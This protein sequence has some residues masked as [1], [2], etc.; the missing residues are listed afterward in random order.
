MNEDAGMSLGELATLGMR[1][2]KEAQHHHISEPKGELT[3]DIDRPSEVF[4]RMADNELNVRQERRMRLG[5]TLFGEP[6]WEIL[7]DAYLALGE[8]RLLKT[9]AVCAQADI[10]IATGLRYIAHLE[11]MGLVQR[12]QA[13]NDSRVRHVTLTRK[14]V[15]EVT[16]YFEFRLRKGFL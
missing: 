10:P 15:D 9:T 4:I 6:A 13:E 11:G 16:S 3:N 1:L 14:G 8:G 5:S 7:L 12:V 2:L